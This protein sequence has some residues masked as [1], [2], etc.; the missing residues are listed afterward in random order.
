MNLLAKQRL[1]Q[2]KMTATQSWWWMAGQVLLTWDKWKPDRDNFISRPCLLPYCTKKK[3]YYAITI[4]YSRRFYFFR[5][6]S[7]LRFFQQLSRI[8]IVFFRSLNEYVCLK[9]CKWL[10]KSSRTKMFT[11]ILRNIKFNW[12][13]FRKMKGQRTYRITARDLGRTL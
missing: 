8:F 11:M 3:L 4:V 12:T 7:F 13:A 9:C 10:I 1:G 6:W 2:L 5:K